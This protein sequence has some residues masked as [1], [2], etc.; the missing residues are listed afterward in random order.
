[1]KCTLVMFPTCV[2]GSSLP[3][4]VKIGNTRISNKNHVDRVEITWIDL[5]NSAKEKLYSTKRTYYSF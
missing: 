5:P 4:I 1:M 2:T 3:E